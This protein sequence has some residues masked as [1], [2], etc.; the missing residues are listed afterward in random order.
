M[1][2]T[3]NLNILIS[4]VSKTW[5]VSFHP[6]GSDI[7]I[8]DHCRAKILEHHFTGL[9]TIFREFGI[10]HL[11]VADFDPR[12]RIEVS[13]G[14]MHYSWHILSH[15]IDISSRAHLLHR[16]GTYTLELSHWQS[17]LGNQAIGGIIIRSRP[18]YEATTGTLMGNDVLQGH[19]PR[20][21]PVTGALK[22]GIVYLSLE[23]AAVTV[24]PVIGPFPILI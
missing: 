2:N 23:N 21:F 12:S 11:C 24:W 7:D 3:F 1:V 4:V 9:V 20:I 14:K 8:L 18:G 22:P 13:E 17:F 15:I 10:K 19:F 6:S 5:L 16:Y